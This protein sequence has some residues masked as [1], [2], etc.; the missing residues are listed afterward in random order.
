MPMLLRKLN[1]RN[2]V[3]AGE[4]T[5]ES[6]GVLRRNGGFFYVTWLGFIEAGDALKLPE[7]KPVKLLIAAYALEQDMPAKWFDLA[8]GQMIQGC[9]VG[10]G[11]YGVTCE[12]IPRL[13]KTKLR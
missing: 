5:G 8:E 10:Y 1:Y 6:V 12:G 11:A 3:L 7:A 9:Y 13:V 2:I 4:C